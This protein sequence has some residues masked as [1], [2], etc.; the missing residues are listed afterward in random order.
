LKHR[1]AG[2]PLET[3]L[4]LSLAIEIADAL[5]AAHSEGIIHRDIKPANIFVTKRGHTKILDFGLAKLTVPASSASQV[6]AEK[7]QSLSNVADEHLTSPGS[8]LGTVVYMSPEQVLGKPLDLRTD[9]FSFGVVLYEM[10]TGLLPFKGDTSGAIFDAI[11]HGSPI[12]LVRVNPDVPPALEHI[13][14]K[15]LEKDRNVRYQHAS[16]IKADLTRA[17]RDLESGQFAKAESGSPRVDDSKRGRVFKRFGWEAAIMAPL[18][19]A[20]L[21]WWFHNRVVSPQIS[22]NSSA[23]AVLPFQNVGSDKDTDFLRLALPDEIAN[24][25]SHAPSLSIRPLTMTAKYVSPDTDL[26]KTGVEMHVANIVT[27]YYLR[28]GNHLRVTLEAVDVGKN[29][30]VWRDSMDVSSTDMIS[31][32]EQVTA[33]VRQGLLPVLGA[34]ASS[35]ESGTRPKSEEAYD[36]YLRSVAVPHDPSP[37][38]EAIAMLERVVGMDQNYAPA[39]TALGKRYYDDAVYAGGGEAAFQRS[40]SAFERA[41]V[42]DPNLITAAGNLITNHVER[43]DLSKAYEEAQELV[44]RHPESAEAH[45]TLGYVVR[46]AGLLE[47][48]GHHCD[49]AIAISPGDFA[50]RSCA[51]AFFEMGKT[52][53]AMDFVRLDAGSEWANWVT[54]SILLRA[55]KVEEA[56]QAVKRMSDNPAYHRDL[57]EACLQ[58]RPGADLDKIAEHTEQA[59]IAVPDPEP[60]YTQGAILAYCGKKESA[61]RLLKRAVEQNYCAYSA[62]QNDPLLTKLRGI[63]EFSQLLS[64]AKDCQSKVL[65][66]VNQH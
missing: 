66:S 45:F 3:E 40:N 26:Q 56:R 37:N 35:T 54:P 48:A 13:I 7:T 8:A 20:L 62:L 23:V 42:L 6:A 59:I 22:G 50:Y 58:T 11:L 30:S 64:A 38:R 10:S 53:R 52:D 9:L 33:K 5:D 18:L 17:K 15:A 2:Q 29:R 63:P 27:G 41:I 46:Y 34:S 4:I 51:W 55:G 28:E 16:D 57:L 49:I 36:L 61:L 39:W 47:E 44:K 32:R 31:M 19:I 12:P 65:A 21:Y 14:T 43:G 1:I 60:V 24:T 25:L